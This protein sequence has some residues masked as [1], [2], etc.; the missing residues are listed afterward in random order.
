[1]EAQTRFADMEEG[2]AESRPL[3][4]SVD[5]SPPRLARPQRAQMLLE[6]CCLEDLVPDDHPVRIV[7]EVVQ[8]WD[9]SRFYAAY[10]ARGSQPGRSAID[11]C[12]LV[13]VCLYGATRNVAS[14]RELAR[15]CQSEAAFRWL[16]GGLAVSYHTVNDFRVGH[17]EALN[18]LLTQMLAV[19]M[20]G[21]L[22][23][24]E[25]I[26][27]DGT[28]VRASASRKSFRRRPRLE[29]FLDE[30][31]QH[32][33][34]LQAQADDPSQTARRRAAH[35]HVARQRVQ[36]LEQ[37]L[38]ELAAL[39]QAKAQQKEKPSKHSVP[40][41]S[42]TD[43]EARLMR[44]PDGGTR[45]AYN[46]QLAADPGSR[47]IVGAAVTQAG[48]DAGQCGPM[49]KQ[50]QERADQA[51]KEQVVDGGY[52]TLAEIDEAGDKVTMYVPV[53]RSQ[54]EGVDPHQPK[55]GDSSCVAAWRQRM[56]TPEAQAIYGQ[57]ASTIET[58]NGDLKT[59]R[60]LGRLLVRGMSKVRCV[61][62]WCALAYNVLHF[63][64]R[65]IT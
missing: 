54:K 1:M 8:R 2:P 17:E 21:D 61:L 45:P 5:C 47:A 36:R 29:R 4:L 43:P 59:H 28:K 60:G 7:W 10:R 12:L 13:A 40:R 58:I 53:P 34:A 6:P 37:S 25:R 65:L 22:V 57:R 16:C 15:L 14:G 31:R 9:L 63:G 26:V 56:G 49:R 41:A 42:T 64:E 33:A 18:D 46:L 39:E 51:V 62:L 20:E 52:L 24:V 19:L 27:Q 11:P 55:R 48:N 35:E 32:L 44:M 30:A 23:H 50:V 3:D 38:S